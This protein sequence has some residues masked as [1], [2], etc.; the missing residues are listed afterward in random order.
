M[1]KQNFQKVPEIDDLMYNLEITMND[2]LSM[3]EIK[4]Q[5]ISLDS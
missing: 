1:Q 3:H 5:K 4:T 2:F